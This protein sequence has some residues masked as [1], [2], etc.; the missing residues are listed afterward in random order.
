MLTHDQ[1]LGL[2]RRK[3]TSSWKSSCFVFVYKQKSGNTSVTWT[4]SEFIHLCTVGLPII[5]KQQPSRNN[6]HVKKSANTN[7]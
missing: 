6:Q 5:I 1:P 2:Q 4:M 3:Q 7:C